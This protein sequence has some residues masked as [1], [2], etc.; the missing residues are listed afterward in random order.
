ME[1]QLIHQHPYRRHGGG[2]ASPQSCRQSKCTMHVERFGCRLQ[3]RN[4][5]RV[6]SFGGRHSTEDQLSRI[7]L[8]APNGLCCLRTEGIH[9]IVHLLAS[10]WPGGAYRS[11]IDHIAINI[12]ATVIVLVLAVMPR[13]YHRTVLDDGIIL[14]CPLW[15][16]VD[17]S[18]SMHVSVPGR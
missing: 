16:S 3:V 15:S 8:G 6:Q 14:H 13:A 7:T 2:H 4:R 11:M 9:L 17:S 10:P 1:V 18:L 5:C 12:A